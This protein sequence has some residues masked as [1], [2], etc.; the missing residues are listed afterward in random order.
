[1]KKITFLLVFLGIN[2]FSQAPAIQWQ[3]SF[4]GSVQDIANAV[5][6]TTDGGY[7]AVGYTYSVDGDLTASHGAADI[8]V[9]KTDASGE[10]QWQKSL[11]GSSYDWAYD[12][13]QTSDG[14]FIIA[15]K[16]FSND[17][18]VI[19]NNGTL[20]CWIVKL[21]P[22]GVL[23]WQKTF[24]GSEWDGAYSL[25]QTNDNG[26]IVLGKTRST[27]GDVTGNHGGYDLWIIKLD[28]SGIL[29]WE[30][31][32]GGSE[33]EFAAMI[34]TTNDGGYIVVGNT[35]SN[36][37]DVTLNHGAQDYWVVKLSA[38]GVIQW[39]K[40]FGGSVIDEAYA[41]QQTNDGGYIVGGW[42]SSADG[43][44]AQNYGE[45]DY[46]LLKLSASGDL[47]W[48]K[49]I[50]GSSVDHAASVIQT[51]DGAYIIGG[52]SDTGEQQGLDCLI[53]K[54]DAS[55]NQIWQKSMG[56]A[57]E[58]RLNN[59]KQTSDGGYIVAGYSNS[60]DGDVTGN[61][62]IYDYWIVK[63][64]PEV[65][66][67]P[68]YEKGIFS[69]YPN[70]ATSLLQLQVPEGIQIDKI[71]ITDALGKQIFQKTGNNTTVNIENLRSGTYIV[72]VYS[73]DKKFQT[74]FIKK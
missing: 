8:W 13:Q 67:N 26:I 2:G 23:E 60:L 63:L 70:P 46:W 54:V 14:G 11:G 52:Y 35:Y 73:A 51:T 57:N 44:V 18:D 43:D 15:G 29:Q 71:A 48:Q 37:G 20:D 17:G 21:N 28:E 41:I 24:G 69:V 19:I 53:Y 65:L 10:M 34:K 40:T 55:G 62:G 31:T 3:K 56:G 12:I 47:Q 33:D 58:E 1:M 7:I 72:Q 9:V 22:S 36:D 27:N 49:S 16:T 74:K 6:E 30:K 68:N 45:D 39:Q 64:G 42:T 32:L 59:I 61:H 4:G 5:V 50:G 38:T 25:Q 66:S